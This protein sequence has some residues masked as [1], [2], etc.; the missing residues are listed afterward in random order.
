MSTPARLVVPIDTFRRGIRFTLLGMA[1]NLLLASIKL[2]A[3][4]VGNAY[5]LVADAAESMSDVVTSL[6]V[7]FGLRISSREPDELYPF[8]YGRAETLAAVA[9]AFV[10]IGTALGIGSAAIHQIQTP[11]QA[12]AAWTLGVLVIVISIKWVVAKVV[13]SVGQSI[14]SR[15]VKADAAHHLSDAI[16]SAAAFVGISIAVWNGPGWESADDWAALLASA[17]IAFNGCLILRDAIHD[18][19]DRKLEQA[20]YTDVRQV[21][22]SVPLVRAIE[23]LALRRMG[24]SVFAEIHVQADPD[25]PL[26]EAHALGGRVKSAI[27]SAHPEI[28]HVLIHIEPFEKQVESTTN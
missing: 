6:F 20:L 28:V 22:E 3:G 18:L 27:R 9:V 12:P 8:G 17:I 16:T 25:L 23:K 7:L 5:V 11:H 24:L 10:L 19:M 2:V 1:V 15:S 14:G 21:A 13:N 4:I 26:S